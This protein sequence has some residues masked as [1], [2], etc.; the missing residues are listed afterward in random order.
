MKVAVV[1]LLML[2][3][4]IINRQRFRRQYSKYYP[5]VWKLTNKGTEVDV[6]GE[7]SEPNRLADIVSYLN[8]SAATRTLEAGDKSEDAFVLSWSWPFYVSGNND[9]LDTYLGQIANGTTVA[10]YSADL[11]MTFNLDVKVTQAE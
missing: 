4:L 10:G 9:I 1:S 5:L 8:S 7:S 2:K 3:Y 6:N 11:T